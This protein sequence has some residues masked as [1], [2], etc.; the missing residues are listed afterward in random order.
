MLTRGGIAGTKWSYTNYRTM[1]DSLVD[2]ID[3]VVARKLADVLNI[4]NPGEVPRP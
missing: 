1:L 3:D 2:T 4:R